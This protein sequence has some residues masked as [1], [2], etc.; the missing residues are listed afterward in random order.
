LYEELPAIVINCLG[1]R[2]AM[3]LGNGH[4]VSLDDERLRYALARPQAGP[5]QRSFQQE[6]LRYGLVTESGEGLGPP[7]PLEQAP[8]FVQQLAPPRGVMD[9][10]IKTCQRWGLTESE[11][12]ILL[13]YRD[14]EFLGVQLLNGRWLRPSQ[15]VKDRVGYVVGISIGLGA[16][17]DEAVAAE[18]TWLK[19]VHPKLG[20]SAPLGYM[21]GGRMSAIMTVA[22]LVAEEREL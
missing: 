5:V 21:L 10:F 1:W 13:G 17:F 19:T 14:N 20:G 11:Q 16:I 9:G 18:V 7:A 2:Q 22:D 12:L 4:N 8:D 15:D 6:N 3:S